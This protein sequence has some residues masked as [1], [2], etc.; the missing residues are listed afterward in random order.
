M[1]FFKVFYGEFEKYPE[2]EIYQSMGT[3]EI[4]NRFNSIEEAKDNIFDKISNLDFS[5]EVDKYVVGVNR[6]SEV[7]VEVLM[8]NGTRRTIHYNIVEFS[9]DFSTKK[10]RTITRAMAQERMDEMLGCHKF[11]IVKWTNASSEATIECKSCGTEITFKHG[12]SIYTRKTQYGG[13]AGECYK[14]NKIEFAIKNVESYKK[15]VDK[16]YKKIED[17]K[18]ILSQ[19]E[20]ENYKIKID[21]L[22]HIIRETESFLGIEKE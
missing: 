4:I 14:C 9:E 13:F 20:V 5:K 8:V 17:D 1:K 16:I 18:D 12:S 6:K 21:N 7:K 22:N 3:G 11:E 2:E 19:E 10:T 15:I